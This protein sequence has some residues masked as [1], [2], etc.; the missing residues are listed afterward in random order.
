MERGVVLVQSGRYFVW[1][2][3][4]A[5]LSGACIVALSMIPQ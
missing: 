4:R 5:V 2:P 1:D 3:E